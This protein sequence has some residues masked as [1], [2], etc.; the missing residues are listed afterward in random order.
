MSPSRTPHVLFGTVGA[1]LLLAGCAP[2]G[3]SPE[4][5]QD[6]DLII[7][8]AAST[9][10]VNEELVELSGTGLE[11][12]NAGSSTLVQQ[13]VDGSPGDVLITADQATMDQAREQGV[14][15]APLAFATN[16][17]VMVTPA[18]NPAGVTGVDSSLR[19]A[20]VVLCDPRVPCGRAAAELIGDQEV[21]AVSLEHSVSDVLGKVTSGEADAGWVYRTDARAAGEAVEVFEIPDSAELPT[22]LY[23]AV[24]TSSGQGSRAAELVALI[25]GPEMAP[26]WADN[27][28]LPLP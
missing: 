22:T 11:F 19:G 15:G 27:G 20:A 14:V 25:G 16:S 2:G 7:L 12:I 6:P 23:A 21:A 13:L 3:T 1:A 5:G 4:A 8:G 24:T 18:G 10:V 28:F 17:L 26:V 9:R